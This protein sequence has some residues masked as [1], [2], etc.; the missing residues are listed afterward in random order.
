[1]HGAIH[2]S[3]PRQRT[4]ARP[5]QTFW[6]A[7]TEIEPPLRTSASRMSLPEPELDQIQPG[8]PIAASTRLLYQ[9]NPSREDACL[10]PP[11]QQLKV[12]PRR[13][14]RDSV[15]DDGPLEVQHSKPL[16][17]QQKP[18]QLLQHADSRPRTPPTR[19][20]SARSD[21]TQY[22]REQ[23]QYYEETCPIPRTTAS[24]PA[25][26]QQSRPTPRRS[27]G[28]T[29]P[30]N[31][32]AAHRDDCLPPV[33]SN[34]VPAVPLPVPS[35]RQAVQI[36]VSARSDDN[37]ALYP[38]ASSQTPTPNQ[39]PGELGFRH[40][41]IHKEGVPHV[42]LKNR[43]TFDDGDASRGRRDSYHAAS[44][45]LSSHIEAPVP[46]RYQELPREESLQIED[47]YDAR[48]E[49]PIPPLRP[50][51]HGHSGSP[52]QGGDGDED[53]DYWQ[54]MCQVINMIA[55]VRLLS[56][57]DVS[58]HS[59]RR[60]QQA[61]EARMLLSTIQPRFCGG[62][63]HR[64]GSKGR[65]EIKVEAGVARMMLTRRLDDGR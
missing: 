4:K 52:S 64:F 40:T 15:S 13:R 25:P 8:A 20:F 53:Q 16:Q 21:S 44:R 18:E 46:R 48:K 62:Y 29:L 60:R 28:D 10:A 51:L 36:L 24:S 32:V 1:M 31:I 41:D 38:S 34:A 12:R 33:R 5:R 47:G 55:D 49:K 50:S 61:R 19:P 23:R 9:A 22:Q 14:F 35:A 65:E 42:P 56:I 63:R 26:S 37:V 57:N 59:A 2:S 27:L 39:Q 43:L 45:R 30:E 6:D 58:H 54:Q 3:A 17:P 7:V 11:P